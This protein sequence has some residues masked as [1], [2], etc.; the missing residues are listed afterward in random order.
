M[1][2]TG[3]EARY[4]DADG[5]MHLVTVRRTACGDWQVL[6]T[7]PAET[8]IVETLD[9]E[10]DDRPQAEAV[11]HDYVDAGRFLPWAGSP[12]ADAIPE[13]RGADGH[14]DRRQ[15]PAS[16]KP[17]AARPALPHPAG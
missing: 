4:R 2:M 10:H 12:T 13:Q 15:S 3:A 5:A 1:A 7:S 6:D 17:G 9:G 16:R 11:A 8:R 14:S